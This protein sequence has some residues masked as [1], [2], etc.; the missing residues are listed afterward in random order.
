VGA[1]DHHFV[2]ACDGQFVIDD[3]IVNYFAV[4]HPTTVDWGSLLS[5]SQD[6]RWAGTVAGQFYGNV[7]P[8]E[9]IE[10]VREIDQMVGEKFEMRFLSFL[11]D[12]QTQISR[13][14]FVAY[15]GSIQDW[16]P[17]TLP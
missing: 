5:F 4:D 15:L 17:V 11:E 14:D 10:V 8:Q 2:Y 3:G 12:E 13:E 6:G 9:T 16:V 1:R 7:S